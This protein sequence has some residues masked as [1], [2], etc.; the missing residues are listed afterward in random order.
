MA[1]K[2]TPLPP[3]YNIDPKKAASRLADPVTTARFAK[4]ANFAAKGRDDLARRGYSPD[5]KKHLRKFSTWEICKYLIPLA[6]AH[7]RRVL[8]QNPDLQIGRAHV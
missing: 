8:K 4:A 5:G 2:D 6:T 3:Y 7:F 1:S